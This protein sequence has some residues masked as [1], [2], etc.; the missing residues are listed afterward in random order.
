MRFV[1]ID[2]IVEWEPNNRVV[3]IKNL[4][5]AEEYLADHFPGFPVLP[6]VLMVE[7]LVQ[8]GAWLLRETDGFDRPVILLKSLKAAKFGKFVAPGGQLR[9]EMEIKSRDGQETTF[10]GKGT[11]DGE[12]AVQGRLVLTRREFGANI[13]PLDGSSERTI[14]ALRATH[15]TLRPARGKAS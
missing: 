5:L 10:A 12:I 8:T 14:A 9:L 13:S 3:S 11:V 15:E 7:A 1:L 4:S 2:R 6:G